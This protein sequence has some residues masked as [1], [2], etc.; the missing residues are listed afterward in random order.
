MGESERSDHDNTDILITGVSR[1]R[2]RKRDKI[3][4][5]RTKRKLRRELEQENRER[6][7][8]ELRAIISYLQRLLTRRG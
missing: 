5:E 2:I 4:H 3:R 7:T 6:Q 1:T 8:G